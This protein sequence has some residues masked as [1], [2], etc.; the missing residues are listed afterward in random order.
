M[1]VGRTIQIF[2]PDGN[3]RS[4]KIAEITSRTVQAILIPRTK[5]ELILTRNELNNV[6][7]YLLIGNPEEEAKPSLYIG[8]AEDCKT[9]LKQHNASKDF[10]NYAIV[11]ISKTHYFT[12]THIKFLESLMYVEASR[13]KR[14][15]L[16]N[17]SVP[18]T[19]YVA[20]WMEADLLENFDSIKILV[21]TLGF[22][23]FDELK[24]FQKT[25]ILYC[26]GKE[27]Q[28]EGQYTDEGFLVYAGSKA[29]IKE[30]L[31]AGPV[32]TKM[33]KKLLNEGVLLLKENVYEFTSDYL[34]GSPSAAAG[35]VLARR[36]NGWLEW[37][38]KNGKTLDEVK[39][40]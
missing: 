4:I 28:A 39:R 33:R 18:N 26:K 16:E 5:L 2:L 34:F 10:W 32:I 25:E 17:N 35:A 14:Y 19:P 15:K 11:I 23:I 21:S 37:K 13:I 38:F 31:T 6:G 29:N 9:R 7:V 1:S 40:K 24:S 22:P 12:K 20:E 27:A 36:A 30:T 8:E 3:P